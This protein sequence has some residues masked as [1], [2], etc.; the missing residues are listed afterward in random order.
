MA[1]DKLS[2]FFGMG[3]EDFENNEE[4]QNETYNDEKVVP[5]SSANNARK[6]SKIVISEPVAYADAKDIAQQILGNK[7]V[8]VNFSKIDDTQAKRI[9]DFLAG[10]VFAINGEI[11]NVG[12]N[13]FLCTPQKFE[14]DG[15]SIIQKSEI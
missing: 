2:N 10:T 8:I 7:A 14:V 4:V 15:S 3:D 13:I 1:F 11:K 9:V 5:M 12:E 6:T